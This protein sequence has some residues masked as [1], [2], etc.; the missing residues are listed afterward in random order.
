MFLS[1]ILIFL[2]FDNGPGDLGSI[3]GRVIP[4]IQTIL[5]DAS[6]LKTQHYEVLIKGKVERSGERVHALP[7]HLG[8]VTI[9]KGAFGSLS[10]MVANFT[11]LYKRR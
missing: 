3:P 8:V 1:F 4:K 2:E 11:Y 6:L 7:S 10:I 5:L 9:E